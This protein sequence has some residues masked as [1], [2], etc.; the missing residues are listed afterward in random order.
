[1]EVLVFV[2]SQVSGRLSYT[3]D[4]L[5]GRLA[6][7][8]WRICHDPHTYAQSASTKLN[9]S[10]QSICQ[11][12]IWIRPH[13]LLQQSG[14]ISPQ[15]PAPFWDP[16]SQLPAI[17][18][19]QQ[20]ARASFS[21]DLLAASFYFVSRYEEYLPY[22]P[23]RHGR[24]P[25]S[26]SM[27]AQAGWLS[28]P[29]VQLWA[30]ALGN[31][32]AHQVGAPPIPVL[33]F[34]FLPTY[35]IDIPWAYKLRGWRGMARAFSDL[36]TGQWALSQQRL[37]VWRKQ[38]PDPYDTFDELDYLH[39]QLALQPIYF[40]LMAPR[41]PFDPG[42]PPRHPKVRALVARLS[43]LYRIG[44]HPSWRSN[45]EKNQLTAEIKQLEIAS[46]QSIRR[47]RQ[48]FL[49][50]RFP[51]TYRSLLA[52]G[53]QE[54]FSLGFADA[55][56][57][58]AGLAWPFHWYDLAAEQRTPL[59]VT[60]ITVM[61]ASLHTYQKLT[62]EQAAE[63]LQ[64]LSNVLQKHGGLLVSLWHNSS[65]SALHGWPA[66]WRQVYEDFLRQQVEVLINRSNPP[67]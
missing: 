61:D 39:Q 25:A 48:H 5:L 31:A 66:R 21:F 16:D 33:P 43:Q 2:S 30:H 17:F 54:D 22:T 44:I 63:Q 20:V 42:A 49:R 10:A 51:D 64:A 60:P 62:P 26:A 18:P 14:A 58:R 27:A 45:E 29:V 8:S 35:D 67:D 55:P 40:F 37:A 7:Y 19:D 36:L 9:Y 50:L 13:G 41:G 47:S 56:G 32:L 46:G 12:E 52:A 28:L 1:M 65:F 23:D 6:G 59:L 53:I 38:Q 57:F 3:L 11:T 4:L 15:Q 34:Q 24:F